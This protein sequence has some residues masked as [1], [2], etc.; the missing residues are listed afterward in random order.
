MSGQTG[1]GTMAFGSA[2]LV[3]KAED[4]ITE[5]GPIAVAADCTGDGDTSMKEPKSLRGSF[6]SSQRYTTSMITTFSFCVRSTN[7]VTTATSGSTSIAMRSISIP[8]VQRK[9]SSVTNSREAMSY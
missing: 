9:L 5:D 7:G 6:S 4:G 2:G 1:M 3:Y 8:I